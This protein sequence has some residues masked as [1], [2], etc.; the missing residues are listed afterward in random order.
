MLPRKQL[1]RGPGHWMYM[2]STY[3]LYTREHTYA[4]SNERRTEHL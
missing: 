1:P 4:L 3:I 2:Y